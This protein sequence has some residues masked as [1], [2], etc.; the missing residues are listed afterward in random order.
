MGA[1][2]AGAQRKSCRLVA[3]RA[4][5]EVAEARRAERRRKARKNGTKPCKK[6]LVRDGW[7]LML[8]NLPAEE[9]AVAQLTA[10]Y[11]ARWAVEIEFRAWKQSLH[12]NAALNRRSN[13]FHMEALVIAAMIVHQLGMRIARAVGRRIGRERESHEKLY[14]LLAVHIA[15]AK[16][17]GVLSE[18]D[19]DPRHIT[20]DKRTRESPI[21]AGLEALT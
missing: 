17:L 8:T 16:T 9:F 14:D 13:R 1:Y 15:R 4:R 3:V 10:L 20:R 21:V 19:P 6:G 7:H 11:R 2:F 12:L 5:P 18:F